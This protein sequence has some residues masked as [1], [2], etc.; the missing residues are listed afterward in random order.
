MVDYLPEL[1][2]FGDHITLRHLL[3]HTSGLPDYYDALEQAAAGAM[4]DTEQAMRFLAGWGEPLFPPGERYEYSNPGYEML[5][6]VVERVSGQAFGQF[7][8]DN[9]FAP[10]GMTGTVVRDS[11]EPAI[12]HRA[13]GY[14]RMDGAIELYDDH[15]LNHIVGSGS[16]FSSVEDLARWDRAL[17]TDALVRRSTLDEAW[18]PVQLGSGEHYPYGFGWR[19]DRRGSLGRRIWHSGGWL[20]F[21]THLVRYPERRVT[22]IVLANLEDFEC[23]ELASRIVDI[24]FPTARTDDP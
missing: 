16:I 11:S 18:S 22:V 20:G 8:R 13:R 1:S 6:L 3:T 4:P 21:S 12:T 9:I 10:L 14:R 15:P 19:L 17:D 7:L 23:E 2:R 24:L 5:A